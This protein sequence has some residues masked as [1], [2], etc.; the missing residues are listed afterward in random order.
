MRRLRFRRTGAETRK[1]GIGM[2]S[3]QKPEPPLTK[4]T[5]VR[6]GCSVH[7]LGL[8]PRTH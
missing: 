1:H 7:P 6:G 5:L 2:E 4:E 8:E 3:A